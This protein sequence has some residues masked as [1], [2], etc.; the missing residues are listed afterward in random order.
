MAARL[1]L[2]LQCSQC[3]K[4]VP[5]PRQRGT[6]AG[7]ARRDPRARCPADLQ[8]AAHGQS[9]AQT[10]SGLHLHLHLHRQPCFCHAACRRPSATAQ[11]RALRC[12]C[13]AAAC[14]AMPMIEL[15]TATAAVDH[16]EA[17]HLDRATAA[18]AR[19]SCDPE[20]G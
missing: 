2:L 14:P 10:Q 11:T 20:S 8:A 15:A 16:Q 6:A 9:A 3:R 18:R 1:L 12:R 4:Q 7:E 5:R 13:D 19:P 17:G